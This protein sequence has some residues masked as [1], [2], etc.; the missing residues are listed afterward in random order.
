M[1]LIG[2][3]VLAAGL[4]FVAFAAETKVK[5][6]D[7]PAAVQ[8]AVKEQTKDATLVGLNKETENGQTV[9]EVETKVNGRT[10]DLLLDK[11]GAVIE[12]E[13]EVDLNSIPAAAKEAIQKQ[14]AGA[15]WVTSVCTGAWLLAKAGLLDGYR[16]T[17]HS[18]TIIDFANEFPNVVVANGYPRFVECGNRFTTG[19]VS[20]S[21][22]GALKLAELITGD[23]QVPK[24]IQLEIQY[25]PQPPYNCGDPAVADFTTYD[26]V[27]G[28][29]SA[30]CT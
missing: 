20:S 6:Q 26:L 5:M 3:I 7:L 21:L 28:R 27:M 12:V 23:A 13:E 17:T 4:S 8:N 19:G 30:N 10:R 18:L 24:G 22:D 2:Y 29:Q 1:R 14:A 16:A 11:T 25:H 9:F 15:R